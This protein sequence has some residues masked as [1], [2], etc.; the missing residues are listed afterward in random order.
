MLILV[1]HGP[2]LNLFGR[3]ETHIY[4]T[5]TLAEINASLEAVATELG[6]TLEILQS[7][8]EGALLDALHAHMDRAAGAL[9]NPGGLTQYGVSLH[10]AI[11]SV[12][13]PVLEVHM[14]NLQ[15]REP[16]RQHSSSRPRSRARCRAWA[17]IPTRPRCAGW[18]ICCAP[19]RRHRSWSVNQNDPLDPADLP[20]IRGADRPVSC[21]MV[22][23]VFGNVVL[24]YGFDSSIDMSDEV[25]RWLFVWVTFLGA[26]V[27]L[28]GHEHLG[29]DMVVDRL[30]DLGRRSAWCSA[31]SSCWR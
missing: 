21:A 18:W 13:Y 25:S 16:W 30:P 6:V 22:V 15:T 19:R 17:G 24:R 8:H 2:N 29:M 28:Q 4:G 7:N 31:M 10:D 20:G 27:A 9:L 5:T 11:K 14:S 3:R 12:N 26:V 1:L 23:L